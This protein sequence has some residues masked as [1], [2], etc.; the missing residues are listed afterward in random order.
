MARAQVMVG[1]ACHQIGNLMPQI[2]T[3]LCAIRKTWFRV[4]QMHSA[5]R[6]FNRCSIALL[7]IIACFYRI[8]LRLLVRVAQMVFVANKH[9]PIRAKAQLTAQHAFCCAFIQWYWPMFM[10]LTIV[11][12][13]TLFSPCFC[14]SAANF[15]CIF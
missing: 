8:S 12:P 7:S 14:Q 10:T 2:E 4:T 9:L 11:F 6:T 3:R 13:H 5:H 15:L 1:I